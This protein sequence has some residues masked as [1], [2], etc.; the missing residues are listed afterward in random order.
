MGSDSAGYG[1][2]AEI[3]HTEGESRQDEGNAGHSALTK[4]CQLSLPK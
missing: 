4:L 2:V 3:Q 1:Q